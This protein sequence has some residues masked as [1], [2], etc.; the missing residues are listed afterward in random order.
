MSGRLEESLG[1][2]DRLLSQL[3]D[4]QHGLAERYVQTAALPPTG[5]SLIINPAPVFIGDSLTATGRLS[6]GGRP[7][8]GRR[9]SLVLDN[10]PAAAAATAID[11]SY[12][13]R[14]TIPP[15]YTDT[16]SLS[17]IY[18]PSGDDTGRYLASQSPPV[19]LDTRFYQSHLE[20][21]AP[22]TAHPG[23]TFPI[24]G[25]VSSTGG[26]TDR[27]VSVR[28][29][30][31]RLAEE[32][33]RGHFRLEVTPPAQL[34]PGEHSLSVSVTPRGRYSGASEN[35]AVNV[36]RLPIYIDSETTKLVVLPGTVRVSGRVYAGSGPVPDAV[37]SIQSGG[38]SVTARTARDGSFTASVRTPLDLSLASQRGLTMT[39]T[40]A[41]PWYTS[42]E[43]KRPL[44]IVNPLGM[45]L[46]IAAMLALW[47]LAD[48][49]SLMRRRE[50]TGV[51][52]PQFVEM[53]AVT[54]AAAPGPRLTGIKGR[55]ISAYRAGLE[56]VERLSGISLGPS[57]TLR[58]FL[59]T[60]AL[61]TPAAI[62]Q[63]AELTAIAEITLYSP[64]R[65]SEDTAARAEKIAAGIKEE[66]RRG[67][68]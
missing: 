20:V 66:L 2:L 17:A 32:N 51:P 1:R 60:A 33:V 11:G 53:P 56:A 15:E 67:T 18:E 13:V 14:I 12:A 42:T 39:V 37:V 21:S 43:A 61:P 30:D 16:M 38:A 52:R 29:D 44:F 36:S 68:P 59:K 54:P 8:A 35:L 57:A 55:I 47:I 27:T 48:M 49:G 62:R 45:E 40:P 41:E 50:K 63:F 25:E 28:L 4:L 22:E 24:S 46:L 26:P 34:P 6:A 7:L 5:L 23:L 64:R 31:T 58:E 9:L 10:Q 65:L 19:L 3:Q